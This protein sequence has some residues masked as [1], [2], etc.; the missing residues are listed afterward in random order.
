MGSIML[1]PFSRRV[2][3]TSLRSE[4]GKSIILSMNSLICLS[5]YHGTEEV[6]STSHD[7]ALS[8][9]Q[10]GQNVTTMI[11]LASPEI[12][13]GAYIVVRKDNAKPHIRS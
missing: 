2:S 10:V 4:P 7:L 1:T 11:I 9:E 8:N 6:P 13:D 12:I 3:Q 5:S